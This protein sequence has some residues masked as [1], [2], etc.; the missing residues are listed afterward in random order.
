[1][2][3]VDI[4]DIYKKLSP[5]EIP[6][7]IETPPDILVELL[8]IGTVKPCKA[9]DLGCGIGHYAVYLAQ[10]GFEVTGIDISPTAI[11]LAQEK[12]KKERVTCKF[13]VG[14]VLGNLEEVKDTYDFA[15]DWSLLHHVY[16][17]KRSIYVDNVNKI[18]N[19]GGHYLSVCFSEKDLLFGGSG[20]YRE[21]PLGTVLYFSSEEELKD[22]FSRFFRII[23]LKTIKIE[24]KSAPHHA[25]YALMV[26]E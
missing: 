10:R 7:N 18:L 12:A 2:E 3:P 13:I 17:E 26:R 24:G 1:L 20:K 25:I 19:S 14:D 21:T 23:E 6:W 11:N 9:V 8:E 22:L 5:E 15:Y 16:P 4:E